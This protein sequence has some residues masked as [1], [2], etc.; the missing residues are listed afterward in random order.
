[1]YSPTFGTVRLSLALLDVVPASALLGGCCSV[2]MT[3]CLGSRIR[4]SEDKQRKR[5]FFEQ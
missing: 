5:S 2:K 1:M 3:V 4:L